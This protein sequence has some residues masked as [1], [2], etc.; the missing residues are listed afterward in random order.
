M[1]QIKCLTRHDAWSACSVVPGG[2]ER[3][4]NLIGDILGTANPGG[5]SVWTA[6]ASQERVLSSH[7]QVHSLV[8]SA[9]AGDEDELE[10]GDRHQ[11]ESPSLKRRLESDQENGGVSSP[12]F[13]RLK[14]PRC[15]RHPPS[16]RPHSP[17]REHGTSMDFVRL[18]LLP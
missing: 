8:G 13:E 11:P 3:K 1:S 5:G 15:Q 10:A 12:V 14:S 17:I 18:P 7:A 9:G 16:G 2:E 4:T 6:E